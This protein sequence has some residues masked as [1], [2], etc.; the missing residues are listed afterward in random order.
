MHIGNNEIKHGLLLAPMAG[1]TDRAMRIV[2]HE[3]R[4]EMSVTEMVSAK[5]VTYKDKKTFAL[6]RIFED[7][8]AVALQLFGSEPS[9][10]A[11]AGGIILDNAISEKKRGITAAGGSEIALPIAFDVNMGCPVNKI[12]S[13]GEGSALMKDPDLIFKITRELSKATPLPVTVKMRLGI[14]SGHINVAECAAAAEEGGAQA[15]CIH[16]R[17]RVQMY[18]GEADYSEIARVCSML[19]IPVIVNGDITSPESYDKAMAKTGAAAAAIGRAAVGNPFVFRELYAHITG[20]ECR[21]V[22]LDERIETALRQLSLAI[23]DKGAE[24]AIPEARKQIALYVKGFR[25]AARIRGEINSAVS[26]EQVRDALYI[27]KE[28]ESEGKE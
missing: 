5:A 6:G 16:G 11:E 23:A 18:G 19:K 1:Y 28:S 8:G 10:I 24:I 15:I 7:E 21:K 26:F 3:N 9:V 13:N 2:A 22:S 25:G 17:T 14:D 12:F 20:K 4:C 27:A